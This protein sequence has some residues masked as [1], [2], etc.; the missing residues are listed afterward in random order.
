MANGRYLKK[1][2]EKFSEILDNDKF[3]FKLNLNIL[4]ESN[5][6]II[7]VNEISKKQKINNEFNVIYSD[8]YNDIFQK[9]IYTNKINYY[10][11]YGDSKF[12]ISGSGILYLYVKE[13]LNL[14]L[15]LKNKFVQNDFIFIRIIVEKGKEL[16]LEENSENKLMWKN[17]I[18]ILE[19]NS[20]CDFKQINY[21]SRYNS[22]LLYLKENSDY[23]LKS[24]YSIT[25]GETYLLNSAFHLLKNSKS[26]L[27]V[28]GSVENGGIIHC[29]GV[30]KINK[31]ASNSQGNQKLMGFILDDKSSIFNEPI[32]EIENSEVICSHSASISYLDDSVKFY[33]NSRGLEMRDIIN[34]YKTSII[35]NINFK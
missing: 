5:N 20:K 7:E 27:D 32:L 15:D 22:T 34:L 8:K 33:L 26:N 6:N 21:F 11:L 35:E 4:E 18:I 30:I 17:L 31:D 16:I 19:D 12:E 1:Q 25:E 29:D 3:E 28:L 14:K 9:K 13:N 10:E 2:F 23:N 24:V